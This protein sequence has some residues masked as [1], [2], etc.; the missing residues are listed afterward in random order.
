[1]GEE[2]RGDEGQ[3]RANGNLAAR[4]YAGGSSCNRSLR[5]PRFQ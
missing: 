1:M 3:R 2:G 5:Y 4:I